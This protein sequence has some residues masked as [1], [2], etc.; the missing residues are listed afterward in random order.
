MILF[1]HI[2]TALKGAGRRLATR[3]KKTVFPAVIALQVVAQIAAE[4]RQRRA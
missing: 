3:K 2:E 4:V 1:E